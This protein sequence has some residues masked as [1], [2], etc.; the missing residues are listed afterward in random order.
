MHMR[1]LIF[2]WLS[3]GRSD[4]SFALRDA[5]K[6]SGNYGN[7]MERNFPDYTPLIGDAQCSTRNALN[8]GQ[9][10]LHVYPGLGGA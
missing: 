2:C 3:F 1:L 7:M 5:G 9:P 4:L 6:L 8:T 10:M